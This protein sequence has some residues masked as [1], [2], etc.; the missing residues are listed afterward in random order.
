MSGKRAIQYWIIP[1][2]ACARRIIHEKDFE[3]SCAS[4]VSYNSHN[5]PC[6]SA[7]THHKKIYLG[8]DYYLKEWAEQDAEGRPHPA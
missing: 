6:L 3:R 4:A 7:G 1:H 5:S 2:I 8:R